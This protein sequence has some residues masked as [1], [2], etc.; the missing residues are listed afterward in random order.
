VALENRGLS[1]WNG[2]GVLLPGIED[3]I[4]DPQKLS[5]TALVSGHPQ[6]RAL[7]LAPP[8][9]VVGLA[10]GS[11]FGFDSAVLRPMPPSGELTLDIG[12]PGDGS[13]TFG[14]EL[15]V[16]T[17]DGHGY[18]THL[19]VRLLLVP[20]K[21]AA[22][23]RT[24]LFSPRVP[25]AGMTDPGASVS[26]DGRGVAVDAAG[27]F[28]TAV[29]GSLLPRDVR[30]EAVDVVGNRASVVLSVVGLLDYR[31]LPWVP[32]VVVLT[33]VAGALLYVR[34]PRLRAQ[35]VRSPDDDAVLEDLDRR[36]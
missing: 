32:L 14:V 11:G 25:V 13:H 10:L 31:Q 19:D 33:V 12:P 22:R 16:I 17:P 23:A 20:P 1:P 4:R 30:I 28:S 29:D 7:V 5:D 36:A 34:V 24:D 26:V 18:A 21:L 2:D 6:V 8:D 15:G 9:S 27:S 35:P 3:A